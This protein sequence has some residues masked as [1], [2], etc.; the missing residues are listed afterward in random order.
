MWI[1]TTHSLRYDYGT[2]AGVRNVPI[3]VTYCDHVLLAHHQFMGK[4]VSI[5]MACLTNTIG[6][7]IDLHF[8]ISLTLP[9]VGLPFAPTAFASALPCNP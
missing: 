2:T 4:R 7:F 1:V 9:S 3:R 6:D 5:D 8:H